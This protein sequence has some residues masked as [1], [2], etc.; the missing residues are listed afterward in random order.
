VGTN[1]EKTKMNEDP[2][3]DL[4]L[5]LAVALFFFVMF[6]LFPLLLG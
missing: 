6:V 5:A 1:Y 3:N 2:K 4:A